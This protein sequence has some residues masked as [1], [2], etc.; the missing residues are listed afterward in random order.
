[1]KKN[2]IALVLILLIVFSLIGCSPKAT[3]TTAT[4]GTSKATII[5]DNSELNALY[6]AKYSKITTTY[7]VN[8]SNIG[9]V[10]YA[11][12]GKADDGTQVVAMKVKSS[13][14][15]NYNGFNSTGWSEA[16]PAPYTMI[17]VI[18]KSTNKVTKWRVLV[19]GTRK[20]EYFVVPDKSINS[21]M[22]VAITSESAFDAFKDG[23]VLDLDVKTSKASDGS[24]II[25]GT[26]IVFTGASEDGTLSGQLV[27]HCFR[28]AAYFYCNYVKGAA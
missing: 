4:T 28:T 10:L 23:L 25:T 14:N 5:E 18:D 6:P 15:F 17:I 19:D 24:T 12:E 21:Y 22:T 1:M 11:A 9:T 13:K 20:K 16:E 27:R 26:S 3:T 2:A 8:E 7:V